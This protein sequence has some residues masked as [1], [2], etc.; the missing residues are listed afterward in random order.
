[1]LAIRHN[2]LGSFFT[3]AVD[4]LGYHNRTEVLVALGIKRPEEIVDITE[5]WI[6]LV[7]KKY[8]EAKEA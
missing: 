4:K 7:D 1:M 3:N 2:N 6:K 5:A 8:P